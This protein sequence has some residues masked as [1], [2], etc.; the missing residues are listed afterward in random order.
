[1]TELFQALRAPGGD[2]ALRALA[3]FHGAAVVGRF[4]VVEALV[5]AADELGLDAARLEAA[6]LQVVPYGGFPRAIE[7]L[8]LVAA[9]RGG[10]PASAP[11]DRAPETLAAA[12]RDAFER[13]YGDN[14]DA[15]L[16]QLADLHGELPGHVLTAAYGKVLAE[17][18]LPL[19]EREL[20]AVCALA[21]AALP[22]PLGSHIRGALRNGFPVAAVEDILRISSFLADDRASPV[23]AQALDRLTRKVYRP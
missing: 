15:V 23:I 3:L 4:D 17:G 12:G 20:L 1:M 19:G 9:A 2:P 6:G 10:P 5:G 18:G 11:D 8:G 13:V 7:A 22:A 21:L 14:T 16:A